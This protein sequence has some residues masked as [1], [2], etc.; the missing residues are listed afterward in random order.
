MKGFD[1]EGKRH[2]AR[3]YYKKDPT[4]TLSIEEILAAQYTFKKRG[5]TLD[6]NSTTF[7]QAVCGRKYR[8]ATWIAFGVASFYM[9]TGITGILSYVTRLLQRM[10]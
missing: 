3:L 9:Q 5:T 8:K 7:G 2:M 10:E 4:S 6:A 1:E